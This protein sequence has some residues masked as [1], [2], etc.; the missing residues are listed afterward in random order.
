MQRIVTL[1]KYT[2]LHYH[3]QVGGA[4]WHERHIRSTLYNLGENEFHKNIKR[5]LDITQG[6]LR[7]AVR[8]FTKTL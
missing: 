8:N 1:L 2:S 5:E 3:T 6:A 4:H 7:K